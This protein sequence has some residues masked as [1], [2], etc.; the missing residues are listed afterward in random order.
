MQGVIF[1]GGGDYP[2]SRFII[3]AGER[4]LMV[5]NYT[6]YG[7]IGENDQLQLEFAGTYRQYH[8]CLMRTVLTGLADPIHVSMHGAAVGALEACQEACKPGATFVDV[9]DVH[10]G[11]LDAAGFGEHRL[12]ACGYSLGALYPP[13]WMD[14]P[15]LYTGNPIVIEPNM[16]IFIHMIMLDSGRSLAMALGETVLVTEA[17]CERLSRM[18]LDLVVN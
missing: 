4:A 3:G 18:S 13:T 11:V 12:N 2:A 17:G 1:R 7:T 15:M 6:G 10:A 5:R 8:A 14:W 9:F 16:V